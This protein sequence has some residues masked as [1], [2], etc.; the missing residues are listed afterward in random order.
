MAL[1]FLLLIASINMQA[2]KATNVQ[3]TKA[4]GL[5][6]NLL[7]EKFKLQ[8]VKV[9]PHREEEKVRKDIFRANLRKIGAHN[10]REEQGLETWR[11]AITQFADLTEEE[12][13][14][15][16]L[17]GYVRTPQSLGE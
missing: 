8:H 11:M 7:W 3:A 9:Y 2:T 4:L 5:E 12:F 10:E 17:G 6:D 13:K 1:L 16:M 15:E 14:Q